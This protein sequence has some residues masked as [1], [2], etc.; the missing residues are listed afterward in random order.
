MA[1][2]AIITGADGGMGQE[3][4]RT[5]SMAGFEVIMACRNVKKAEAV[6]RRI[7]GETGGNI[8]VLQLDLASVASIFT[9]VE[10]VKQRFAHVDLL[11]NNAGTLL[12]QSDQTVDGIERTVGVNYLGHYLL[13]RLL[14]P[15]IPDGSR[16]VNMVSLT[17][18]FGKLNH[19]IFTPVDPQKF[20]RFTTYSDSK[21]ALLYF[22]L[23]LAEELKSR[24]IL[25]N[26]ADPG[27]VS[28]NIIRQG[29]KVVD[30]LCDLFFRPIIYS[31]AKGAST[32]LFLAITPGIDVTGK[33]FARKKPVRLSDKMINSPYREPLHVKTEEVI[34]EIT[35]RLGL[36]YPQ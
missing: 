2:I 24:N 25:V 3:H 31:P 15:L 28:T 7:K 14:L 34:R 26:C 19:D 1:K 11:L 17:I 36:T 13:T 35:A 18:R 6:C 8:H 32:M 21:L 20:N 16:I 22:T 5:V 12:H 33:C 27:I 4:T 10:E 29:N 9:F 30:T 23:D